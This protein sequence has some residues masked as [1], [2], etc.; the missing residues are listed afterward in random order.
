MYVPFLCM[1]VKNEHNMN[2][3]VSYA[4]RKVEKNWGLIRSI[5]EKHIYSNYLRHEAA[6][7]EPDPC[8]RN[9]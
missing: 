5:W 9:S 2:A 1:F 8:L 3:Q 4:S 7:T 6:N